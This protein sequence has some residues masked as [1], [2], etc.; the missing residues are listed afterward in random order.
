MFVEFNAIG[1]KLSAIVNIKTEVPARMF[2]HPDDR[3]EGEQEEIQIESLT[4]GGKDALFLLDSYFC[5]EI[6]DAAYNAAI[7]SGKRQ[8]A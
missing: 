1:L 2:C 3:D 8:A 5:G 6:E 7:K 4:C